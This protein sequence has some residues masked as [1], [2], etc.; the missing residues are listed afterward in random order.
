MLTYIP[1]KLPSKAALQNHY[2]TSAFTTKNVFP[3]GASIM[4]DES[5]RISVLSDED[6]TEKFDVFTAKSWE[7][8][9]AKLVMRLT[10]YRIE[11]R[12]N[13]IS[14]EDAYDY[15]SELLSISM[16]IIIKLIGNKKFP[17]TVNLSTCS[18]DWE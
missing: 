2:T 18:V 12:S 14:R 8:L 17:V 7:A 5:S 13:K 3:E 10:T 4:F 9:Q 11:E 15:S 1:N 6:F 16:E